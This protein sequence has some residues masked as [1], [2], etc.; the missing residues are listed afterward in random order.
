MD[1]A[2]RAATDTLERWPTPAKLRELA[3][4]ARQ[5]QPQHGGDTPGDRYREWLGG[6]MGNPN[7]TCPICGI[8][9]AWTPRLVAQCDP[10]TH[11]VANVPAVAVAP[12]ALSLHRAVWREVRG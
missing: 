3:H 2:V 9:A 4:R 10:Q 6:D 5:A 8:A 1:A 11:A 7:A 12:E